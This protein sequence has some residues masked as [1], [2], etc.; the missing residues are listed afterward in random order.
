MKFAFADRLSASRPPGL[1]EN[2]LESERGG[3]DRGPDQGAINLGAIPGANQYKRCAFARCHET[4]D[5]V[6]RFILQIA[7]APFTLRCAGAPLRYG[8]GKLSRLEAPF[9]RVVVAT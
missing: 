9:F 5:L 3:P 1:C 8:R 6:P 4:Q 2:W 7:K